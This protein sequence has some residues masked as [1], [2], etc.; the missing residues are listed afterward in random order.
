MEA[1]FRHILQFCFPVPSRADDE[2][3]ANFD[4]QTSAISS[5]TPSLKRKRECDDK[6]EENIGRM[7]TGYF[8]PPRT[9]PTQPFPVRTWAERLAG[10]KKVD[11]QEKRHGEGSS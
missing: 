5:P 2:F 4:G 11:N 9:A 3:W 7:I 1:S 6:E 10:T 8:V